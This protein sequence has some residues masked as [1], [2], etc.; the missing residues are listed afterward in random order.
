MNPLA[1]KGQLIVLGV[2]VAMA[3]GGGYKLRDLMADAA[4]KKVAVAAT[5]AA[6]TTTRR[7]IAAERISAGVG[8][9]AEDRQVEIR[10][11]TKTQIREVP[12]YVTAETDRAFPMPVGLVRVFNAAALGVPAS[13][14][15]DPAGRPDD[16]AS[17]ITASALGETVADDFGTC[18]ADQ[19]RL[20]ALQG[21]VREQAA[22]WELPDPR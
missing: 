3:F 2:S 22:G 9:K 18:R 6:N 21:W 4:G 16:A 17:T 10:Y 1:I 15:P 20:E 8:R 7:V 14:L 5:K 12:V 13:T 19:A 11:V